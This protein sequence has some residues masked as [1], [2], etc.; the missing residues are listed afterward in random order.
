MVERCKALGVPFMGGSSIPGTW[1]SPFI[2]HPAGADL[3]EAVIVMNGGPDIYGAHALETLQA[4]VE[5]RGPT[6]SEAGVAA[7]QCLAGDRVW[8]AGRFGRFSLE[9]ALAAC[10]AITGA[11]TR[12]EQLETFAYSQDE[13]ATAFLIEYRDGFCATLLILNGFVSGTG[14]A[15]CVRDD[16]ASYIESCK[17]ST[18]GGLAKASPGE[19]DL[20]SGRYPGSAKGTFAH[21]SYLARNVEEMMVTGIPSTPIERTLLASGMLEA[22]LVSRREGGRRVVTD[23]LGVAYRRERDLPPYFPLGPEPRGAALLPWPPG[24]ANL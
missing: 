4:F 18:Y 16:S 21:F 22:A 17:C 2:E 24:G 15:A 5:R 14:Y 6:Q 9:L 1:R 13:P 10:S 19:P 12:L 8:E 20:Y 3:V 11:Q 23:W 7:V